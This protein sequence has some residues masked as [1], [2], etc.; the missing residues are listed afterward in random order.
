MHLKFAA[1]AAALLASACVCASEKTGFA[2]EG[3]SALAG[4]FPGVDMK[5]KAFLVERLGMV[6][7]IPLEACWSSG[8]DETSVLLGPG[9][10][11]PLLES[12]YVPENERDGLLVQ[13]EG[14]KR[15]VHA[16]KDDSAALFS[17]GVWEGKKSG[18]QTK[19]RLKSAKGAAGAVELFYENGRLCKMRVPEGDFSFEYKNRR[20]YKINRSGKTLLTVQTD[21]KKPD[22]AVLVFGDGKSLVCE[23]IAGGVAF[24]RSDGSRRVYAA[25]GEY[26][27][28]AM[29]TPYGKIE[30]DASTGAIRSFGGWTYTI[31]AP[32]PD[33]NNARINRRCD[34]DG[35]SESYYFDRK[36]GEGRHDFPNG[37]SIAWGVFPSGVNGGRMRWKEASDG[38]QTLWKVRYHYGATSLYAARMKVLRKD[39]TYEKRE[40]WYNEAGR[41]IRRRIDGKD[42]SE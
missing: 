31:G 4:P 11:I 8:C 37:S 22:R 40:Y 28:S 41:V 38:C 7:P 2:F 1:S 24:I 17:D 6:G 12:R 16:L 21:P 42:V 15:L 27:S 33:W 9:W 39:G 30:W 32:E 19:F 35:R 3:L 13:P 26:S 29:D 10:R 5:G 20:P 34:A 36:E 23:K 18:G 25:K 14:V